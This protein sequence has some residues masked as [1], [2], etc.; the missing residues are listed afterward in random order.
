VFDAVPAKRRN[1]RHLQ[2]ACR[3]VRCGGIWLVKEEILAAAIRNPRSAIP[4]DEPRTTRKG[5]D[6]H[7]LHTSDVPI[8]AVRRLRR[9]TSCNAVSEPGRSCRAVIWPSNREAD[10][11]GPGS[12]ALPS[13]EASPL[14]D[15][16]STTRDPKPHYTRDLRLAC[17]YV[18][19]SGIWLVKE[20]VLVRVTGT[21]LGKRCARKDKNTRA[22]GA[23]RPARV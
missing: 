6:R 22:S 12:F 15:R 18:M 9:R 13:S 14:P 7:S 11:R 2:L 20:E 10:S 17:R 4:S 3:S 8:P 21:S 5:W 16:P 1:G 23:S 19:G